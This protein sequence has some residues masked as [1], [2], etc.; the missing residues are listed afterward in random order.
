M[1]VSRGYWKAYSKP[2]V[3]V[4]PVYPSMGGVA[5]SYHLARIS[6][7]MQSPVAFTLSAQSNAGDVDTD[8]AYR[9]GTN[10][11]LNAPRLES[12]NLLLCLSNGSIQKI[13]TAT[14]ELGY[15]KPNELTTQQIANSD[16]NTT[17]THAIK[18]KS[19][20]IE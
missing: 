12:A 13:N 4:Q 9:L 19:R 10:R 6:S 18:Y 3:L 7:V 17:S 14:L 20:T 2:R 5:L 8:D 16:L 11:S 15:H 1:S